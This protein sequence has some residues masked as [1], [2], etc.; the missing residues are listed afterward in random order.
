[1]KRPSALFK[2]AAVVSSVLLFAGLVAYR[3]GAFDRV[4]TPEAPA[5]E[6]EPAPGVVSD[7]PPT[8]PDPSIQAAD[9]NFL[10]TSKSIMFVVPPGGGKKDASKSPT[11]LPGSKSPAPLLLPTAPKDGSAPQSPN[12]SKDGLSP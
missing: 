9:G 6:P 3:A 2:V 12:K 11:L 7:A 1:M 4:M 10:S 8:A 5:S